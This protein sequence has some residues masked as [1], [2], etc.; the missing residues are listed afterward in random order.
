M[1]L[2]SKAHE[3]IVIDPSPHSFMNET[4]A[5]PLEVVES[6]IEESNLEICDP[7][8]AIFEIVV[9][10]LPGAPDGTP[11]PIIVEEEVSKEEDDDEEK[12]DENDAKTKK[13]DKWNWSAHG[14][15]GFI[16]WVKERLENVPKHSGMDTA[17]LERAVSYLDKLDNEISKA[18]RLDL[19]GELDANKIEEVRAKI[20][21]G[22][23]RLNDRLEKIKS[24][25]KKNRRKK[26][27]ELDSVIVKE[28]Q[29]ITG[30]QG[31]Y[32]T[33]PLLISAIGRICVN[34]VVSGGH[35]LKD[36]FT[37][38]SKKFNLT[39]REKFEVTQFLDAMGYSLNYDRGYLPD[40]DF[41][42]SDNNNFDW[43]ANYK[44]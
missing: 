27:A 22:I 40:E 41:D 2:V 7:T 8:P 11:D 4:S 28:A 32:V 42:A 13:D 3:L 35:E 33:V 9:G 21:D 29:K 44:G 39:A 12:E 19:D 1:S 6:P 5:L 17:G 43:S 18:M 31:V 10:D 30:V 14:A 23:S 36:V 26:S 20:D 34:S 25:K 38:L 15:E 37:K 24:S 16:S